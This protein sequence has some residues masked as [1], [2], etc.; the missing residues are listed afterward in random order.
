MAQLWRI[1][2]REAEARRRIVTDPHSPGQFRAIGAIVNMPEFYRAFDITSSDPMW[3]PPELRA[4][5]W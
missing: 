4:K 2:W 1:N 3:R 5:V